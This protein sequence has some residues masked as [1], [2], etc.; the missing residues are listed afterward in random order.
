[1]SCCDHTNKYTVLHGRKR[2][3]HFFTPSG[4]AGSVVRTGSRAPSK[5]ARFSLDEETSAARRRDSV[6]PRGGRSMSRRPGPL[7]AIAEHSRGASCRRQQSITARVAETSVRVC[8]VADLAARF[9]KSVSHV[10]GVVPGGTTANGRE[11]VIIQKDE[12]KWQEDCKPGHQWVE[13]VL[14]HV[15]RDEKLLVEAKNGEEVRVH[16]KRLLDLNQPV[17]NLHL[18]LEEHPERGPIDLDALRQFIRT[19]LGL[20]KTSEKTL[21]ETPEPL[22]WGALEAFSVEVNVLANGRNASTT[23]TDHRTP[24]EQKKDLRDLFESSYFVHPGGTP[25][26]PADEPRTKMRTGLRLI[27]PAPA[28]VAV[29]APAAVPARQQGN[30]FCRPK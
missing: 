13:Y 2:I 22:H 25:I 21:E 8:T 7:G 17:E 11:F 29:S 20:E 19:T 9:A 30:G 24:E 27:V 5:I 10:S 28:A 1:M 3:S 26:P 18:F 16:A 6:G 4:R 23:V 14:V 15:K 12:S